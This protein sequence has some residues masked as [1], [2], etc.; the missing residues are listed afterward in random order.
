MAAC[1]Q[2]RLDSA[3]WEFT[4]YCENLTAVT[5]TAMAKKYAIK[6][7]STPARHPTP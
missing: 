7:Q 3:L 2:R 6:P 1:A 4:L 5:F